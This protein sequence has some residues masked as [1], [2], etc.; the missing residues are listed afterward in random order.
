LDIAPSIDRP[1]FRRQILHRTDSQ[2]TSLLTSTG[3][4]L[5]FSSKLEQIRPGYGGI[6]R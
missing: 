4:P 3:R 1:T 6:V 2:E 5:V